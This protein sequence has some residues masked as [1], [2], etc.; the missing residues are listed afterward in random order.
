M[1]FPVVLSCISDSCL[2]LLQEPEWSTLTPLVV[3]QIQFWVFIRFALFGLHVFFQEQLYDSLEKSNHLEQFLQ[4]VLKNPSKRISYVRIVQSKRFFSVYT[5]AFKKQ[6]SEGS[7][8]IVTLITKIK[9][10][11]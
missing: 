5:L 1:A 9:T 11:S 7:K 4:K 3:C 10:Y 6:S 8:K 2:Y